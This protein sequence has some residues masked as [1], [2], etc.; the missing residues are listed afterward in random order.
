MNKSEVRIEILKLVHRHDQSTEL[1]IER[2]KS[3]DDW[4]N[5]CEDSSV[6]TESRERRRSRKTNDA[7]MTAGKDRTS[8]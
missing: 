2:A 3:F 1:I 7:E 8:P 6:G 5:E 4:V